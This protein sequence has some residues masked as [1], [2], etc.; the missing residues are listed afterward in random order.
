MYINEISKKLKMTKKAINLYEEKGLI[1]PKKDDKG[2]RIYDDCEE[3]LILIQQLRKLDFS[4]ADI[5]KI[6]ISHDY[7]LFDQKKE[8]YQKQIYR[9]DT[10]LQ[11]LDSI[12]ECIIKKQDIQSISN[13]M[14]KI[15]DL[16]DI[17]IV[18]N[19]SIDFDKI[20]FEMMTIA[21][22]F[23]YCGDNNII[24]KESSII[25][26]CCATLIYS[27]V[28]IRILIYRFYKKFMK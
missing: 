27:Q 4:I 10:S 19:V 3:S 9:I 5:K 26:F 6:L 21:L 22:I 8:I 1:Q 15:F 23:A 18:E 11:Y 24:I 28:Q 12:K 2:Y 17:D 7:T 14:N 25:L 13:E 20:Y 16:E